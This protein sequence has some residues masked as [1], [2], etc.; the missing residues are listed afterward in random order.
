MWSLLSP[1]WD[2]S[3]PFPATSSQWETGYLGTI[4]CEEGPGI[5]GC[6]EEARAALRP[7]TVA[8]TGWHVPPGAGALCPSAAGRGCGHH[9]SAPRNFLNE[10]PSSHRTALAFAF[11]FAWGSSLARQR[12]PNFKTASGMLAAPAVSWPLGHTPT[13]GTYSGTHSSS[14]RPR[15]HCHHPEG[16]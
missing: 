2:R 6:A 13:H 14:E 3:S 8:Q 11:A 1:C 12:N 5:L 16:L 15:S 7:V 9:C 10:A 4:Q